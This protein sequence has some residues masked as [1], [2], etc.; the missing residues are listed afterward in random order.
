MTCDASYWHTDMP[1]LLNRI[2]TLKLTIVALVTTGLGVA[3]LTLA[4]NMPENPP[5]W[6]S[7]WP[8]GEIGGLLFATGLFGMAIDH[9]KRKDDEAR[10]DARLD[11]ALARNIPKFRDAVIEGFD[12][13]PDD[14]RRVATPERL[15]SIATN[16]LSLRL[17]DDAFAREI[18]EDIRDQA[19]RTPE[20]W[21]DVD[22]SIRL[23]GIPES[24]TS[25]PPR[26]AVVVQCDYSVV[27]SHSV[28]RFACV[29]DRDEYQ[30]L[31]ADVPATNAWFL[32]PRPG[33]D[34][35]DR[36]SFELLRFTVDGVERP[37]RRTA[38]RSGQTYSAA[39][40][41]DIVRAGQLVRLNY[42]LRTVTAQSGHR[43]FFEIAQPT[44]GLKLTLDYNDTDITQMSVTDLVS[45]TQKARI[46]RMPAEVDAKLLELDHDGWLLPRAGFAF[47]WTLGSEERI[48]SIDD[49][50]QR[51]AR[52][53]AA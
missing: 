25:G 44:K 4:F 13:Q 7:F 42:V 19:I 21:R 22:V 39:I 1:E 5:G 2:Y 35:G 17:G 41:D 49:E 43:L 47:V 23:S 52:D 15:D 33:F 53:R 18:Y 32:T 10:A 3:L 9:Y 50:P 37:I 40:G 27:P 48:A 14:L 30:D 11:R 31:M 45:S 28:Q 29:S 38:R 20:R 6:L 26:F 8:I 24:T 34:A 46:S 36:E 16:A 12:V 51:Y